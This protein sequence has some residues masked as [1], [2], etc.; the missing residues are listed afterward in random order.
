[1]NE[2][3]ITLKQSFSDWLERQSMHSCLPIDDA[4]VVVAIATKRRQRPK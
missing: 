1:M 2:I 3:K 4:D